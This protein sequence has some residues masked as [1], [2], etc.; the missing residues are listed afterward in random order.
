M[1][2]LQ[3]DIGLSIDAET[4]VAVAGRK[5]SVAV[6]TRDLIEAS[7][8]IPEGVPDE[9]SAPFLVTWTPSTGPTQ[10]MKVIETVP[11]KLGCLVLHLGSYRS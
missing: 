2:G 9:E 7:F 1:R 10:T 11:D 8:P 3:A 4:G 6:S 5:A